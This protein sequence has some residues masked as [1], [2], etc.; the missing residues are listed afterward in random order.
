[1]STDDTKYCVL[2]R[3]HRGREV[4]TDPESREA[5]EATARRLDGEG[6]AVAS[7]MDVKSAQAYMQD[8]YAETY[9][10]VRVPDDLR[11][12]GATRAVF[13]EWKRGVDAE[14]D[15]AQQR[16]AD[17]NPFAPDLTMSREVADFILRAFIGLLLEGYWPKGYDAQGRHGGTDDQDY[18]FTLI[19]K[20]ADIV[21]RK[22]IRNSELLAALADMDAEAEGGEP[23]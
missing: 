15:G 14:L 17:E 3:N 23:T 4:L 8:R 7:V 2:L 16:P 19:R 11:A 5:A 1:V 6:Y 9:R 18:D 21:G 12:G 22:N 10:G 20:A 13:E